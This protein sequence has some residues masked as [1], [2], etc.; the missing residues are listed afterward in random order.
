MPYIQIPAHVFHAAVQE[1]GALLN[2]RQAAAMRTQGILDALAREAR[3]VQE[4]QPQAIDTKV[5]R[6]RRRA[7]T[8]PGND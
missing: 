6:P 8:K 1:L 3:Q 2:E 5:P 7:R 4:M